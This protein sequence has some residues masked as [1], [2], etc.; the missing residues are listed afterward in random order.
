MFQARAG[1]YLMGKGENGVRRK[2]LM[3]GV[4][5]RTIFVQGATG[6]LVTG[7]IG[8]EAF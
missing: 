8:Y 1:G 5:L 6:V 4:D 3:I 7:S 2:G